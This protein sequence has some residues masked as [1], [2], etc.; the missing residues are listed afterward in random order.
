[1]CGVYREAFS[2]SRTQD[3]KS[4]MDY[5]AKQGSGAYAEK[6]WYEK[7]SK[8]VE[9][10]GWHGLVLDAGCGNG[11]FTNEIIKQGGNV[12]GVDLSHEMLQVAKDTGGEFVVGDLETLP[13]RD[14]TFDIVLCSM[15]LHHFPLIN[16]M[17][18]EVARVLKKDGKLV[19]VDIL[20]T[21]FAKLSRNLGK[22]I[23]KFH[24]KE[25]K[26]PNETLHTIEE[27]TAV[28]RQYGLASFIVTPI[29]SAT[30]AEEL[31]AFREN[32]GVWSFLILLRAL[33][34]KFFLIMPP[35]RLQAYDNVII[36]GVKN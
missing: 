12:V 11:C 20:A 22:L 5:W 28:F 16:R 13:F 35:F 36:S 4:E 32:P 27:Y 10:I 14:E 24:I 3:K 34:M 7:Y 1:M 17:S 2:V 18:E 23:L 30:L 33:L 26:T 15:V 29:I 8:L 25:W 19:I 31:S 9:H 21:S 6:K